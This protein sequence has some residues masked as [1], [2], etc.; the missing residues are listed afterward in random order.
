MPLEDDIR[1]LTKQLERNN[2]ILE[3]GLKRSGTAPATS[4]RP[5]A[6]KP[7]AGRKPAVPTEDKVRE[8]VGAYLAAKDPSEKAVRKENVKAMLSHF[9]VGLASEIPEESRAE[10]IAFIEQFEAGETPNFMNEGA[11]EEDDV[12]G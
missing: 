1:A 8:V 6:G 12:L 10:A 9:G 4:A 3:A 5:P 2:N 7:A 11:S